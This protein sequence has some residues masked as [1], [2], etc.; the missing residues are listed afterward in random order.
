MINLCE[1]TF[2]GVAIV[3]SGYW[4]KNLVRIYHEI[5]SLKLICD[6]DES[7]ILRLKNKYPKLDYAVAFSDVLSRDD[8]QVVVIA[9]PAAMHYAMTKEALLAEKHV[10]VKS[11][12]YST[13]RRQLNSSI[14]QNKKNAF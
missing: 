3:G 4:G 1:K 2:P 12:W 14:S 11:H 7:A 10:Y 9:T 8:I 5:G 13:W 6:K